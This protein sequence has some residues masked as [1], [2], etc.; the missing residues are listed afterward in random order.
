MDSQITHYY[1]L[2]PQEF[3]LVEEMLFSISGGDIETRSV[4]LQ[5]TCRPRDASAKRR[6]RLTFVDVTDM[7]FRPAHLPDLSVF[8]GIHLQE[9]DGLQSDDRFEVVA[10]HFYNAFRLRCR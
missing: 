3:P 8:L 10:E 2:R 7:D 5:M 9:A 4:S 1:S 6:L